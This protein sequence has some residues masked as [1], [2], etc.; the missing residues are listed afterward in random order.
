[1]I[2]LI[3]FDIRLFYS[4]NGLRNK[5]LDF[6]LPLFSDKIF[7]YFFYILF[8]LIS[9]FLLYRASK[10]EVRKI[11]LLIVL[12]LLGFGVS[13]FSCGKLFKP[14][15]HRERPFVNLPRVYYYSHGEFQYL[16]NPLTHKQTKSFPSCHA[17]NTAY[18]STFLSFLKPS[19]SPLFIFFAL[20]VGYSRIYLGH[21]FPL[22]VF[23][24][25]LLG[26]I[27]GL[28]FYKS[29]KFLKIY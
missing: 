19:L 1:L 2:D 29:L 26:F 9:S 24:G 15:F 20:M 18:A 7:I 6:L 17:E 13:D 22:D 11:P 23:F 8:F 10:L 14:L 4:I 5:F 28:L 3:A 25:Y 12:F 16:N 27:I 21:H